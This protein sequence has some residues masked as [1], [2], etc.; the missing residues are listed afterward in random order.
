MALVLNR[1]A[2]VNSQNNVL[3][4]N[5]PLIKLI[6]KDVVQSDESD[7]RKP[8]EQGRFSEEWLISVPALLFP[9]I[10]ES[11]CEA[12][13]LIG[14]SSGFYAIDPD[15]SGPLGP[16]QVYCNMT[17]EIIVVHI[18]SPLLF[19]SSSE[20]WQRARSIESTHVELAPHRPTARLSDS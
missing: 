3:S 19:L 14:S 17:G 2:V 10:Y 4:R 15:G 7:G 12:Y 18:L 9:A 5:P 13:K 6:N 1:Q 8:S 20:N 11:S 16:T